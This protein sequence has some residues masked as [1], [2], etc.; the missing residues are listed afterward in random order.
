MCWTS[1]EV[2]HHRAVRSPL[3]P[4]RQ[5]FTCAHLLAWFAG[6]CCKVKTPSTGLARRVS[7]LFTYNNNNNN[8]NNDNNDNNMNNNNT[9]TTFNIRHYF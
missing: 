9:I 6:V 3:Q 2:A 7:V 1:V 4:L 5:T 8:N